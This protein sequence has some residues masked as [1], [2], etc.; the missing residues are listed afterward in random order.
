MTR[1]AFSIAPPVDLT[2]PPDRGPLMTPLE[3][4]VDPELFN[5]KVKPSWVRRN[6]RPIVRLGHS[7]VML[8]REDV[9][10]WIEGRRTSDE[11]AA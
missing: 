11:G 4:A 8:Y 7:T 5:G 6:V 3:V 10:R 1:R 9:R 2:P